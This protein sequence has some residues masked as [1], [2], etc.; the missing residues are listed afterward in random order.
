MVG[1]T[2]GDSSRTAFLKSESMNTINSSLSHD[3]K[4]SALPAVP[5]FGETPPAAGSSGE[6]ALPAFEPCVVFVHN[7]ADQADSLDVAGGGNLLG[8]P[9]NQV[10]RKQIQYFVHAVYQRFHRIGLIEVDRRNAIQQIHVAQR[11]VHLLQRDVALR[12][13]RDG[14]DAVQR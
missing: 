6:N 14:L 4:P 9:Q 5:G 1:I 10:R 3:F 8:D 12:H 2:S 11:P 7:P 13:R